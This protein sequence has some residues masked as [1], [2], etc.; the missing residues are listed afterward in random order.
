MQGHGILFGELWNDFNT[1]PIP[2]L[3]Y[4]KWISKATNLV[5]R[6]KSKE[7]F[8]QLMKGEKEKELRKLFNLIQRSYPETIRNHEIFPCRDARN[9]ATGACYG[10]LEAFVHLLDGTVSGWEAD[11]VRS[12]IMNT[13][14]LV[15][16]VDNV[17]PSSCEVCGSTRLLS[18]RTCK[19][20][21]DYCGNCGPQLDSCKCCSTIRPG[22]IDTDPMRCVDAVSYERHTKPI[23]NSATTIRDKAEEVKRQSMQSTLRKR[24]VL[25]FMLYAFAD[26]CIFRLTSSPYLGRGFD[27]VMFL[28]IIEHQIVQRLLPHHMD[29]PNE[30]QQMRMQHQMTVTKVLLISVGSL[31]VL[32]RL[33]QRL[34]TALPRLRRP[35]I[36]EHLERDSDAMIMMMSMV[37]SISVDSSR[38]LLRLN[39]RL[40]T[41]LPR[42]RRPHNK[43][44]QEKDL[45][46]TTTSMTTSTMTITDRSFKNQSILPLI[47]RI[48]ARL[49]LL[50]ELQMRKSLELRM[51]FVSDVAIERQGTHPKSLRHYS[52]QKT[53][54]F[55]NWITQASRTVYKGITVFCFC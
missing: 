28:M 46:K 50:H 54:H 1:F 55:G 11:E 51:V 20:K 49:L 6:A 17:N 23:V 36:K 41:A 9:A 2:I 42:P 52:L 47:Q 10:T 3:H 33:N 15:K 12:V 8:K 39:R 37:V 40:L 38:V 44:H 18:C 4:K 34:L 30:L 21:L 14:I 16:E 5:K 31:R 45:G 53:S 24:L 35:H 13:D 32:L 22:D 43:E 29:L 26:R 19:R 25:D 7:E 48:L 27:L